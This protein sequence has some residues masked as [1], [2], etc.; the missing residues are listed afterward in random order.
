MAADEGAT[1]LAAVPLVAFAVGSIAA[2]VWSGRESLRLAAT[3]RYLVGCLVVAAVLLLCLVTT[4][5]GGL[6]VVLAGA[7]AGYGVLNVA[8]FELL[9][10]VVASDRAVEAFTWLT[11]WSGLGLAAGA[12]G[13]G[14]LA[15][16]RPQD[17]LLLVALPAVAAAVVAGARRRVYM[18]AAGLGGGGDGGALGHGEEA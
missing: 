17:A 14:Q 3:S 4:S 10:E 6:A 15:S 11:T 8:L 7:G 12:A 9:E 13:A 2:S 16:N 5:I 18:P 1:E